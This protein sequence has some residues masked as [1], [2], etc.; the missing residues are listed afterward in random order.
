MKV[1]GIAY[2]VLIKEVR[3]LTRAIFIVDKGGI[4]RYVQLV[5]EVS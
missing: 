2:G 5:K 3:L 4:V 1:F